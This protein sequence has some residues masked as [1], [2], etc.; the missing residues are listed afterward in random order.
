M[1]GENDA[2]IDAA[3]QQL[4]EHKDQKQDQD[5]AGMMR[6]DPVQLILE[7]QDLL[8]LD[9]NIGGRPLSSA[10][11]LMDHHAGVRQRVPFSLGA[12]RQEE[13]AHARGLSQTVSRHIALHE[14]HRIVDREARGHGA[15][16]RVD[17]NIDVLAGIFHVEEEDL[18]NDQVRDHIIDRRSDKNNTILKK[19]GVNVVGALPF[20]GCFDDHRD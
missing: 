17:I 19:A 7:F 12:G 11:R 2:S 13:R 4:K 20:S 6:Q 16:G 8:G 15:A 18:G 5:L 9:M 10:P 14:A 3:Q 1:A